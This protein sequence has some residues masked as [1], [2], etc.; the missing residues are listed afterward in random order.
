VQVRKEDRSLRAF[1]FPLQE[2]FQGKGSPPLL[3]EVSQVRDPARRDRLVPLK[4]G[5]LSIHRVGLCY[6]VAYA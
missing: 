2:A 1:E 4:N 6:L 5:P 3:L